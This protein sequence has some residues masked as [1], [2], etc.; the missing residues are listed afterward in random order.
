MG[1]VAGPDLETEGAAKLLSGLGD[2]KRRLQ[3][4]EPSNAPAVK[5]EIPQRMQ[6]RP[7]PRNRIRTRGKSSKR[8][9]H[10][11]VLSKMKTVSTRRKQKLDVRYTDSGL[12]SDGRS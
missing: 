12:I 10:E 7:R 6:L 3:R 1:T 9:R 11:L 8:I 2:L 5:E 4:R